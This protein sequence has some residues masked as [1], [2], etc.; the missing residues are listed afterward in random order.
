MAVTPLRRIFSR[1]AQ[2]GYE[3]A[4]S[5]RVVDAPARRLG[6]LSERVQDHVR[7]SEWRVTVMV[8]NVDGDA[9]HHLSTKVG[10]SGRDNDGGGVDGVLARGIRPGRRPRRTAETRRSHAYE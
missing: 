9:R 5:V 8:N 4:A 7:L 3:T 6:S 10:S 2:P 1:S